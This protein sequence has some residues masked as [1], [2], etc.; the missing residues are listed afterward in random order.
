MQQRHL[1]YIHAVPTGGYA[2]SAPELTILDVEDDRYFLGTIHAESPPGILKM[3]DGETGKG[4]KECELVSTTICHVL[5]FPK[6]GRLCSE[7][8]STQ[9]RRIFT[10]SLV[11]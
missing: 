3:Y 8:L 5:V 2:E 1:A 9:E 7:S 11:V 4:D 10:P 6:R